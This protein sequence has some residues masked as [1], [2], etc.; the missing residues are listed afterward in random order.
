[1]LKAVLLTA[2]MRASNSRMTGQSLAEAFAGDPRTDR[3]LDTDIDVRV[4]SPPFIPG[5]E[6]GADIDVR[7]TTQSTAE[8]FPWWEVGA[9]TS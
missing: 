3:N 8:L 2:S 6:A 9:Q 5:R 1:M 7:V 4:N